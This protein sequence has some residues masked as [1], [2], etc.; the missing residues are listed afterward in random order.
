MTPKWSILNIFGMLF[1][2]PFSINFNDL[3]K[4]FNCNQ[5]NAT[6]LFF[7]SQ[8]TSFSHQFCIM[9][10]YLFW[11]CSWSPIFISYV[12]FRWKWS[13]GG[14]LQNPVGAPKTHNIDQV[15]PKRLH[16][17]S[18]SARLSAYVSPSAKLTS[19]FHSFF[20]TIPTS[21]VGCAL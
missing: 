17:S 10:A 5:Y 16:F 14:P 7:A 12:D 21:S 13:I 9:I 15:A 11:H 1:G 4:L 2:A 3:L 19:A 6:N 8:C 20:T 18:L